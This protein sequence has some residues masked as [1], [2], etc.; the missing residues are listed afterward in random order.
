MYHEFLCQL[1]VNNVKLYIRI[2]LQVLVEWTQWSQLKHE[3]DAVRLADANHTH[4]VTV[5]QRR[6]HTGFLHQL[7]LLNHNIQDMCKTCQE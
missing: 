3:H 7:R 2:S 6:H 4:D 1:S 5:V